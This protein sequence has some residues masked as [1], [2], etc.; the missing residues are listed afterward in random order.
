VT[1]ESA[2]V[3][4]AVPSLLA[5]GLDAAPVAVALFDRDLRYRYLNP[6]MA[7]MNGLPIEAH[8]GRTLLELFPSLQDEHLAP[9][10]AVANGGPAVENLEVTAPVTGEPGQLR[11]FIASYRP[12]VGTDGEADGVVAWVMEVTGERRRARHVDAL[13]ALAGGLGSAVT[14][15]DVADTVLTSVLA[16][17]GA[18][19]GAVSLVSAD[20][21]Y[22]DVV[23]S[24]GYRDGELTPGR[25]RRSLDADDPLA[26]VSRTGGV[27]LFESDAAVRERFPAFERRRPGGGALA[28]VG[29]PPGRVPTGGVIL[30][31]PGER[32]VDDADRSFLEACSRLAGQALERV[33]AEVLARQ[34]A[35]G[36]ARTLAAIAGELEPDRI[37]RTLL[38]EAMPGAG[39]LWGTVRMVAEDE[40]GTRLVYREGFSPAA[41]GGHDLPLDADTPSIEAIRDAREIL[42]PDLTSVVDRWPDVLPAYMREG[43]RASASVPM[44][45][46]KRAIG[47]LTLGFD[48]PQSF[49]ESQMAYVRALAEATSSAL[50]R[51]R[52]TE[53]ERHS[54]QL[55]TE[56]LD[57]LP[58]GVFVAEPTRGLVFQNQEVTRILGR[59][60]PLGALDEMT[61]ERLDAEGQ[62]LPVH[63][64]PL[65]RALRR[66]ETVTAHVSQFER[67]DG[68]WITVRTTARPV[69][70]AD[71][72][73]QAAVS[74][75]S[76][77]TQERA[78]EDAREAF[79]GVLSHELRTPVTAIYG[80]SMLLARHRDQ[81]PATLEPVVDD[82][83]AEALRLLRLV[84][85]LL[86]IARVERG[87][88]VAAREPLLVQ[89][90]LRRVLAEE[91]RR[92][93]GAVFTADIAPSLPPV[94]GD[95]GQLEVVVR[96]LLGNAAKYA[97]GG[98]HVVAVR[99][100]GGVRVSVEDDGPGLDLAP[101]Q[102]FRLFQRGRAATRRAA[103]SGIGLFVCRALIEGMGGRIW[104]EDRPEGGTAFRFS[105]ARDEEADNV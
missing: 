51:A 47:C 50:E 1:A 3:S 29:M 21:R 86:V 88:P 66:G 18:D 25:L 41:P 83:A 69:L 7:R 75:F 17:L 48:T 26:Q 81:V 13:Q 14:P 90:V 102:L 100:D 74:V 52:L 4:A 80:G 87:L 70:G 19:R 28:A 79:L 55:L 32:T 33:R 39:A 103:G 57:Q 15:G 99:A 35:E 82:V 76:D 45:R 84:E 85:D 2:S 16:T 36:L 105:L 60:L 37:A 30:A 78:A 9:I 93:P 62:P 34:R 46:G 98:A 92:W 10:R 65:V 54:R 40:T 104:A 68:Q 5:Q 101:D 23:G 58:I 64:W 94:L 72:R 6:A 73:V 56:T 31:W 95:S 71:G 63:D 61:I 67:T 22:L 89:H 91:T 24:E 53:A 96:N 38:R 59:E 43:Q 27:L 97:A 77:I 42:I 12:L 11:R 8:L 44:L 20:G 49:D